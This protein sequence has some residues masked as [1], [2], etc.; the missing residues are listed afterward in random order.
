MKKIALS[1][2]KTRSMSVDDINPGNLDQ[3]YACK[4]KNHIIVLFY[5]NNEW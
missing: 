5:R 3:F 4:I 1:M 2:N